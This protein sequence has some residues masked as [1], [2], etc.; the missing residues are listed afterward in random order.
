MKALRAGDRI[1]FAIR[2]CEIGKRGV[3][4]C[5]GFGTGKVRGEI[6][7]EPELAEAPHVASATMVGDRGAR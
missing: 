3:G 7:L 4:A 1:P 2:R 6:V 5:G